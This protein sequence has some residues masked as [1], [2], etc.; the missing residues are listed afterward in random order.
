MKVGNLLSAQKLR[1]RVG[2]LSLNTC[3]DLVIPAPCGYR[4]SSLETIFDLA[5]AEV[6]AQLRWN[7]LSE[8]KIGAF[9]ASVEARLEA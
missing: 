2:N 4:V 6:G 9:R 8:E 3:A 5:F 7:D 1:S